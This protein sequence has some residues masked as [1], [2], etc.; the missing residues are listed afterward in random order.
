MPA[1]LLSYLL[2][3]SLASPLN[4]SHTRVLGLALERVSWAEHTLAFS[5]SKVVY[6]STS[7]FVLFGFYLAVGALSSD[8]ALI[9]RAKFKGSSVRVAATILFAFV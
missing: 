2:A 5:F 7:L 6:T 4:R 1:L 8:S 9:R 3:C